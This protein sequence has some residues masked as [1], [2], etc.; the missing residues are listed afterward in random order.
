MHKL[1]G[2]NYALRAMKLNTSEFGLPQQRRRVYIVVINKGILRNPNDKSLNSMQ[3][4]LEH[5]R[6][7]YKGTPL[8]IDTFV[9]AVAARAGESLSGTP[10]NVPKLK[11]MS[12]STKMVHAQ[13]RR[14][15]LLSSRDRSYQDMHG[16]ELR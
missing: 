12:D 4:S 11:E 5:I 2:K 6:T 16:A 1:A 8:D 10:H 7:L 9:N 3:D 14:D 15:K 13:L